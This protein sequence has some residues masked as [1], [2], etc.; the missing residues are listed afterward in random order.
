MDAHHRLEDAGFDGERARSQS[1]HEILT[2]S[3]VNVD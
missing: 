3:G 1:G 2:L